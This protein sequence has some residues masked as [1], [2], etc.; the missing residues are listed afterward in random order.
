MHQAIPEVVMTASEKIPHILHRARFS[1]SMEHLSQYPNPIRKC[2]LFADYEAHS[3]ARREVTV[4]HLLLGILREQRAIMPPAARGAVVRAVEQAESLP[5][6]VP[7]AGSTTAL[8][9]DADADRAVSAATEIGH[10]AGRLTATPSDL[11]SAILETS[12]GLAARL[13]GEHIGGR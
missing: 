9:L 5:R 3:F 13:L 10:A 1:G 11:A 4:N 12:G 6:R 2:I 7:A 8:E